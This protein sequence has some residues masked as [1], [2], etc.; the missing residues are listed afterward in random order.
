MGIPH[1]VAHGSLRLTVGTATTDEDALYVAESL[2][3]IVS[4]LRAM[5]PLWAARVR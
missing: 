4:R 2:G 1:E 5:S 3:E